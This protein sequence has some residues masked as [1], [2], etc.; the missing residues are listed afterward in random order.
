MAIETPQTFEN[1]TRKVPVFVVGQFILLVNLI[2]RLYELRYGI[3][4]GSVM[5]VLTGAA[6]IVL[7]VFVRRSALTVQDRLI[8]LEMCLRLAGE[9]PP[10]LQARIPDFTVDQLISL[11]FAGDAELPELARKVLD[12]KMNDRTAIKKLIKEWQADYLRA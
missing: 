3:S 1:H 2:W 10:D 5:N 9:L 12:E 8:R 6:L 4:F 7:F 11:R